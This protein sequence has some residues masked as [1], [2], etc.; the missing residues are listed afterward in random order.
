MTRLKYS[1]FLHL[2]KV[3]K[4]DINCIKILSQYIEFI[5]QNKGFSELEPK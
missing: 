3:I 2:C 1:I 4:Q 5:I